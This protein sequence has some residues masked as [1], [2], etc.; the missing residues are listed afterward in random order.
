MASRSDSARRALALAVLTILTT[1]AVHAQEQAA[2]GRAQGAD[3]AVANEPAN[4]VPSAKAAA[5]FDPSGNWVSL[6]TRDW[7]FRMVVPGRGEYQGMPLN[8]AG[9]QFA[10]A[11]DA[12]KDE[13]AGKQCEAYGAGVVM[14]VP[15]RLK[16]SW[17]DDETLQV[18]TDAGMQT[19]LLYF[20]PAAALAAAPRSWQGYSQATWMPH[21]VV[22]IYYREP[23]RAPAAAETAQFGSLKIV[24]ANMLQG[25]IRKNGVAYS[26]QSMLTEYWELQRDP[27]TQVQYLIVTARLED[28]VYLDRGYFYTATFQKEPDG[29]KWNP[30]PCTLTSQP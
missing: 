25:L 29:S 13:A 7:R 12:A 24:T 16:I 23:T 11:W 21:Q 10:D 9:K 6:V 18:E 22:P 5:P 26:D 3:A 4:A 1:A 27:D 30:T 28:P 14:L 19:R 2:S 17:K 20:Q 15:G 8:L